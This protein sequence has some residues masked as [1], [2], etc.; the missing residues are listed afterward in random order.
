VKSSRITSLLIKIKP[1]DGKCPAS[2]PRAMPA[3]NRTLQC[4]EESRSKLTARLPRSYTP[5]APVGLEGTTTTT[6]TAMRRRGGK[7][8]TAANYASLPQEVFD[9]ILGALVSDRKPLS[10]MLLSMVN[11]EFRRA[12][13]SN[14]KAWHQLYLLW[15]GHMLKPMPKSM[16]MEGVART[17][18]GKK[19]GLVRLVPTIPRSVPNFRDK[20]PPLA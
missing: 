18:V 5:G 11:R 16:G 10:V 2:A 12:V 9:K 8:K 19:G 6:A 14:L 4:R 1:D 20:H 15:R 7:R 13:D 17:I 3:E